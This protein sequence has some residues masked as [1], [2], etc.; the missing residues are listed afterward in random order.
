MN[1]NFSKFLQNCSFKAQE[2][3]GTYKIT[4]LVYPIGLA[5]ILCNS[6]FTYTLS[7][8]SIDPTSCDTDGKTVAINKFFF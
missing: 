7:V 4:V 1:F 3:G 6:T 5:K 2:S 8:T